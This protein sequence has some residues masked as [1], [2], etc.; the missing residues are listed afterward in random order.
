VKLIKPQ[1][2]VC[3]RNEN[4]EDLERHKIYLILPD[5]LAHRDGYLRIVDES[6]EDYLYPAHYFMVIKLPKPVREVLSA[7]FQGKLQLA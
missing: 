1:F 5:E 3:I 6:G 2:A 7:D 4:C